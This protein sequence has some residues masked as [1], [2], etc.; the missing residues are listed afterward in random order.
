MNVF[1]DKLCEAQ[2]LVNLVDKILSNLERIFVR[3]T[4]NNY[5]LS[6]LS[7]VSHRFI[8]HLYDRLRLGLVLDNIES[9]GLENIFRSE[10][11]FNPLILLSMISQ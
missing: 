11:W 1:C 9:Q 10:M 2:A 4:E 6:F 5:S 3:T 7:A 8:S